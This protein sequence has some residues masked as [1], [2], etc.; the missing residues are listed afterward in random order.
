MGY[1]STLCHQQAADA[2]GI[3]PHRKLLET[4][5]SRSGRSGKRAFLE[6]GDWVVAGG[7][8]VEGQQGQVLVDIRREDTEQML[9]NRSS[10][11]CAW[12]FPPSS[13]VV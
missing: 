2:S 8:A 4:N 11:L 1:R 3:S 5:S 9:S 6:L 7:V 13:P 10:F 12:S